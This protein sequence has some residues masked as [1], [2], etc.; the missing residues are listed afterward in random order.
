M[1]CF[2]LFGSVR[3]P[4][5]QLRSR[6]Q[7]KRTLHL[8]GTERQARDVRTMRVVGDRVTSNRVEWYSLWRPTQLFLKPACL[9]S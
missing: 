8:R 7:E 2:R 9:S 6:V 5:F 1:V 3:L 4:R